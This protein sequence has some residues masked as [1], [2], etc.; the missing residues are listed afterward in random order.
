M[1]M[2]S[3]GFRDCIVTLIDLVGVKGV[4]A[5]GLASSAMTVMHQRVTAEVNAGHLPSHPYVYLWNDSV[6]LL[7][8]LDMESVV[9]RREKKNKVLREADALKRDIDADWHKGSYA[10]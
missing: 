4:A 1:P 2:R 9:E 5:Q 6:L 7:A 8:Y 10:I 3:D